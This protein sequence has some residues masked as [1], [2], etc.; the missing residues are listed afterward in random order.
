MFEVFFP[1][2]AA[3]R[4]KRLGQLSGVLYPPPYVI[5]E[6][7]RDY[8]DPGLWAPRISNVARYVYCHNDLSQHNIMVDPKTLNV[9]SIIDW[10]YSGFFPA[11]FEHQFWHNPNYS[12]DYDEEE[13][14]RLAA[15]LDEPGNCLSPS[16][17]FC[18][19][20]DCNLAELSLIQRSIFTLRQTT[21]PLSI[22]IWRL[23][24]QFAHHVFKLLAMSFETL[25]NVDPFLTA[26]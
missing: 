20:T 1:Q 15:K 24:S 14:R 22:K 17:A 26:K 7:G 16:S 8:L 19:K 5:S 12:R 21:Q 25:R 18:R 4:S 10:E 23:Y 9:V 11:E 6:S 13:A 2:L 3:L